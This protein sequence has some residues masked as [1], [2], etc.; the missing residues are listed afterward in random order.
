MGGG[1]LR[2]VLY[3]SV[4]FRVLDSGCVLMVVVGGG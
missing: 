2:G 4:K 1:M 3:K